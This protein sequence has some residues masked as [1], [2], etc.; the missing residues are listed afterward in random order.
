MATRKINRKS[1]KRVR[2]TRSKRQKGG[3][4]R[5][6]QAGRLGIA[7]MNGN[8]KQVDSL[9][10][11]G[12]PVDAVVD[13]ESSWTALMWASKQGH[14]RIVE[15]LLVNKANVDWSP[16][17]SNITALHL[18]SKYGH[19]DIVESLL[20]NG[21]D[22]NAATAGGFTA[23]INASEGGHKII[24]ELLLERPRI[25]ITMKTTNPDNPDRNLD[26]LGWARLRKHEDIVNILYYAKLDPPPCMSIAEYNNCEK[27]EGEKKEGD[28][29]P[30]VEGENKPTC[31]ISLQKI[32]RKETVKLPNQPACYDRGSLRQW[33]ITSKTNPLTRAH[34][35]D[36]WINTNMGTKECESQSKG[37]NKKSKKSR[38]SKKSKKSKRRKTRKSR[39]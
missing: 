38:K 35:E 3:D 26:A 13:K 30:I 29:N 21:A 22:V 5:E 10:K 32:N 34:V 27:K 7:A 23:L 15:L 37:G 36:D 6:L 20:D 16:S 8:H 4:K 11:D 18:A 19:K 31:P 9:L 17:H 28:E 2:K 39:T 25:D 14:I 24:V 1:N 12:V 33:F